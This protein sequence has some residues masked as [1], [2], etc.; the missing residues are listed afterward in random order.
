AGLGL[1]LWS[2]LIGAQEE[3]AEVRIVHAGYG[4]GPVDIYIQGDLAIE[5][6][7]YGDA[8]GYLAL[9]A[10]EYA[11]Q[12][13]VAGG[14]PAEAVIDTFLVLDGGIPHTVV[15]IGPADQADIVVI[16]DDH[17]PPGSSMAKL[18]LVNVA[19]D[20]I[21]VGLML[22]DET[23]LIEDVPFADASEYLELA[24]GVYDFSILAAGSGAEIA[25]IPGFSAESG[26]TYSIF[27]IG[28]DGEYQGMVF[29]DASGSD[30][31][32][33]ATPTEAASTPVIVESTPTTTGA[34]SLPASMTPTAG[35]TPPPAIVATQLPATPTVMPTL[36]DTG[37]GGAT[38][39]G[40]L[41]GVVLLAAAVVALLGAA[42]WHFGHLL[43]RGR[44]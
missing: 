28:V 32:P 24:A 44:S 41:G 22:D 20:G 2:G 17:T 38:K 40:G 13:T 21:V 36:P 42:T 29:V 33:V 18:S 4:I 5:A 1:S 37:A 9:P 26:A 39:S 16:I 34:T 19:S 6:L 15:A 11:V 30:P 35:T 27:A 12:M 14:D 7:E 43:P 23:A 3:D 10:G 25:S 31:D 8:T